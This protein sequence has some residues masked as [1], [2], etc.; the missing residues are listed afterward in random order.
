M[1][2]SSVSF[3]TNIANLV[4]NQLSR[5]TTLNRHQLAGQVA[6]LDFWL[7]EIQHAF[8][9]ID[10][11]GVRFTR[12][13]AAQEQHVTAHGTTEFDLDAD[14]D[15]ERR[16]SPPR[17]VPGQELEKARHSLIQAASRFLE[18]CHRD[19]FLSNDRLSAAVESLDVRREHA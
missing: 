3:S 17:R 13:H 8:A 19:G 14:W 12:M 5:L 9:V 7:G 10:G 16:A 15:T 18:R 4:A 2:G 11:Y 6:N 1:K